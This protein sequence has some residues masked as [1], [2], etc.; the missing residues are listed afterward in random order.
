[1]A[2]NEDRLYMAIIKQA[3]VDYYN[4]HRNPKLYAHYK[5]DVRDW[6]ENRSGTFNLCAR[7]YKVNS[8]YLQKIMRRKMYRIECG[9]PLRVDLE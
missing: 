4:G 1:M 8:D 6:V 5:E 2:T 7:A 3:I 9:E